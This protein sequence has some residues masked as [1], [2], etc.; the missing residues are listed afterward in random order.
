M[1]LIDL[2]EH[3]K[4]AEISANVN[5]VNTQTFFVENRVSHGYHR[6]V[7]ECF[8]GGKLEKFNFFLITQIPEKLLQSTIIKTKISIIYQTPYSDQSVFQFI[9]KLE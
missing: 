8:E 2:L 9:T 1:K 3:L 6:F 7:I 4:S 5:G